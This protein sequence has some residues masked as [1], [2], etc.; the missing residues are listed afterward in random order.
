MYASV[1]PLQPANAPLRTTVT[2]A[3]SYEIR[4]SVAGIQVVSNA[5]T[6]KVLEPR[7]LTTL[8]LSENVHKPVLE[9]Y[10]YDSGSNE[11]DL[12]LLKLEELDF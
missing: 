11:F 10:I 5:L 8:T 12:A 4:C 7:A 9:D 1:R 3:G 2:E 6:L